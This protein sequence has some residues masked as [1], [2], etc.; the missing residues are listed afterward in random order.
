MGESREGAPGL[1]LSL[2]SWTDC[3]GSRNSD[4]VWEL[5]PS[6]SS[7]SLRHP[8]LPWDSVWPI[9]SGGWAGEGEE[10]HETPF[11]EQVAA[12]PG[13]V[14]PHPHTPLTPSECSPGYK[15]TEIIKPNPVISREVN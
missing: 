10:S 8:F 1:M 7:S 12:E 2:K 4:S 14:S 15:G 11:L 5:L 13:N 6:I 9:G 3:T